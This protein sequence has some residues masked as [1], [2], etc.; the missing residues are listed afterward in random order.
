MVK[1]LDSGIIPAS[2]TKW[3]LWE[4]VGVG[5]DTVRVE[6]IYVGG[7]REA[8]VAPVWVDVCRGDEPV[9]TWWAGEVRATLAPKEVRVHVSER[10]LRRIDEI[11]EPLLGH[12]MESVREHD[13][14]A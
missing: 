13:E 8:H 10:A 1:L 2:G 4:D 11:K 12:I 5:P 14:V 6:Y 7:R 9:V 3:G